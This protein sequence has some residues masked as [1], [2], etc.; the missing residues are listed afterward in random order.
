MKW[1]ILESR[2]PCVG[3]A[4]NMQRARQL[5][6]V[7]KQAYL[8]KAVQAGLFSFLVVARALLKGNSRE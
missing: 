4:L 8:T 3:H 6:L 7:I 2:T 5:K 1:E